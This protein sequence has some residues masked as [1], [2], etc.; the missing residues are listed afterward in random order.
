MAEIK[1]PNCKT[2]DNVIMVEY[3][4]GSKYH[5][6]G[7]SEY[8]CRDCKA[9]WNRWTGEM[10]KPDEVA[11]MKGNVKVGKDEQIKFDI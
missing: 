7:I 5:Y 9:R 8:Y 11:T 4:G 10:L 6:D 2:G 3:W 1:C